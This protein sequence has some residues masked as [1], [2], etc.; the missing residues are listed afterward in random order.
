MLNIMYL[1]YNLML[2]DIKLMLK[3]LNLHNS[4]KILQKDKQK[5]ILENKKD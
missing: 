2:E 4:P 5:I 3:E 1:N